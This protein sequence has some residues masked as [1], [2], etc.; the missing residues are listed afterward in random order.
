MGIIGMGMMMRECERCA[1]TAAPGHA[2]CAAARRAEAERFF[3][4]HAG[5]SWDPALEEE[6]AAHAAAAADLAAAEGLMRR[7]GDYVLWD[8]EL[9]EP[10]EPAGW[11]AVYWQAGDTQADD[12]PVASI[13][14]ICHDMGPGTSY[15]RVIAAELA[16]EA[17]AEK[18]EQVPAA[19]RC[20]YPTCGREA[21]RTV[22]GMPL[23]GEHADEY[24]AYLQHRYSS[25][26]QDKGEAAALHHDDGMRNF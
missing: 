14:G 17:A 2:S 15:G 7:N 8:G 22:G 6:D 1:E 24:D 26:L 13:G 23:C 19:E 9:A 25:Y 3:Y 18:P 5:F 20:A 11:T 12:R 16:L 4:E 10:G 21:V